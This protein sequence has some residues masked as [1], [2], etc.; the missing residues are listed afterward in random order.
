M[1]G[2]PFQ[3]VLPPSELSADHSMLM[4]I[5]V[6]ETYLLKGNCPARLTGTFLPCLQREVCSNTSLWKQCPSNEVN[7]YLVA[8][9]SALYS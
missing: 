5:I 9:G 3:L 4:K 7:T 1:P 6:G 2:P 8:L